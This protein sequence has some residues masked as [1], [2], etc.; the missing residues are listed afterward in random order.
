MLTV[1]MHLII[2]KCMHVPCFAI[3]GFKFIAKKFSHSAYLVAEQNHLWLKQ[4]FVF[5]HSGS[6]G[7]HHRVLAQIINTMHDLRELAAENVFQKQ[8]E[9]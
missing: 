5:S 4:V 9:H 8:G 3:F 7:R 2:I 6:P 1:N